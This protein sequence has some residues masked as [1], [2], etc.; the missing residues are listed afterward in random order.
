MSLLIWAAVAASAV[1]WG[2]H[3]FTPATPVPAQAQL[4][5]TAA[6]P[7]AN[8]ARLLGAPPVQPVA[9]A[10]P[11]AAASRFALV[12]VVAPRAGQSSGLALL[13]V[14]GKPA[15]ALGVGQLIEPGIQVLRVGHR[16]VA[17]GADRNAPA[18]TLSLPAL[19]EPNRG[20]P[21]DAAPVAMAAPGPGAQPGVANRN[22]LPNPMG[23]R[24]PVQPAPVPAPAQNE[25]PPPAVDSPVQGAAQRNK[26]S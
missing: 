5:G 25:G 4:A 24:P 11:V 8:L 1:Y 17:L 19:P 16:E 22:Q 7:T 9:E 2:L 13:S 14:D 15:R 10:A 23:V 6:P 26:A 12:G 18:F 3:L 21:G 20:R